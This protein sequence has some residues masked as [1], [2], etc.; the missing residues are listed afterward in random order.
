LGSK[1][2]GVSGRL[3]DAL[4]ETMPSWMP[5][6]AIGQLWTGAGASGRADA[7]T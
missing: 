4:Y 3:P 6:E 7:M 2:T 1:R 5:P